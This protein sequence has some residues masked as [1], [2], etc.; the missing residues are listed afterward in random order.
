MMGAIY[1]HT[2]C[3]LAA[4]GARDGR[5]GLFFERS[6]LAFTDCPLYAGS[7]SGQSY[8]KNHRSWPTPLTTRA[9]VVQER[10]LSPRTLCFGTDEVSW[11][12]RRTRAWEHDPHGRKLERESY[13]GL[14]GL[15]FESQDII[16]KAWHYIVREY[17][18]CSLTYRQDRWPAFQGLAKQVADQQNWLIVH[19]LRWHVRARDLLWE[20]VLPK[21]SSI[22][23]DEPSWSWLNLE[24]EILMS[25]DVLCNQLD[26]T[27]ILHQPS[28]SSNWKGATNPIHNGT[29]EIECCMAEFKPSPPIIPF[30]SEF[31][32]AIRNPMY[33]PDEPDRS[34]HGKWYPDT[35]PSYSGKMWALQIMRNLPSDEP[36]GNESSQ[37]LVVAA[38]EGR[39]GFWKRVGYYETT[40]NWGEA[41]HDLRCPWNW[42]KVTVHLI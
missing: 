35:Y 29:L 27:I 1:Q 32:L 6:I 8:A 20:T 31:T 3:T 19:G 12:F 30:N 21:P 28:A 7:H 41:A 16:N 5:R 23:L 39:P 15:T 13:A 9:W 25:S 34:L 11:N 37:G 38:V 24:S 2:T 36:K 4:T 14:L 17:T 18:D 22:D 40:K 42:E 33:R 10:Y 26:A